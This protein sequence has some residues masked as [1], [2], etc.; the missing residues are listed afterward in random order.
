MK[1]G[2][3]LINL[4]TPDAPDTRSVRRYLRE[5][6]ADRRVIDLPALIRYP[7]LYGLILPFRPRQSAQAYQAIWK[8]GGSPLLIH[9]R[10]LAA[11]LQSVLGDQCQ[12]ALG[13]RYGNP[14]IEEALQQL[15]HCT[16]ITVLPLYPQY[17]SAATGSSIENV[18]TLLAK[19]PVQP[20][21]T[22]I[23]D[24]YNHPRFLA[25]QAQRIKPYLDEH[26]YLLLSFHG[27]PERHLKASGCEAI[28]SNNC[29]LP[30]AA[31]Q[32]CYRAQC[33]A[34]GQ[35]LASRLGLPAGY[36][37]IAFQSRLGKTPWIKPYTDEV[38]TELASQGIKRLAVAC[39]SFVADCLET[40]EEIG[41]RAQLQWMK[42][43]GEKLTVIPCLNDTPQWVESLVDIC[44]LRQEEPLTV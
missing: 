25:A 44:Q 9:S 2:L 35:L 30:A 19:K 40:L 26:D 13:M 42:L 33:F 34:T 22:I 39:P 23:R 28:C 43:G 17:S 36:Y 27:V 15:R 4:G 14:S 29:P 8:E 11:K 41:L 16:H 12:V 18:L 1:Q 10:N 37:Q 24:F 32:A 38:L 31:N 6:L 5:F 7:L 20:S 21:L 3:L